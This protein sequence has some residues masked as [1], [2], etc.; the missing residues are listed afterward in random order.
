MSIQVAATMIEVG[1][2]CFDVTV[3]AVGTVDD[4]SRCVLTKTKLNRG[5]DL[6]RCD[7]RRSEELHAELLVAV[8]PRVTFSSSED[9]G[10]ADTEW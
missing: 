1:R 2:V 6:R 8:S 4:M 5:P 10:E 9:E 3:N 7:W